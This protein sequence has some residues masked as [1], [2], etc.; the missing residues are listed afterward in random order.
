MF[1]ISFSIF[2]ETFFND[3]R[4]IFF[5]VKENITVGC[6]SSTL[7]ITIGSRSTGNEGTLSTAFFTSKSI[8]SSSKS[9]SVSTRIVPEFSLDVEV[10]LTI[11][12]TPFKFSS[13]L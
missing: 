8:A 3:F 11:P 4:S 13:I 1:R 12:E 9:S 5:P 7:V 2:L 10:T 6:C